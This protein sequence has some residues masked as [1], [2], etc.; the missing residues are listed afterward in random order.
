VQKKNAETARV[1]YECLYLDELLL[2]TETA[3]VFY[4]CLYLDELLLDTETARVFYECLFRDKLS[5][6]QKN[7]HQHTVSY[8]KFVPSICNLCDDLG[9]PRILGI[10][11]THQLCSHA[12]HTR[13]IHILPAS[14]IGRVLY[15]A[16]LIGSIHNALE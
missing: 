6:A 10:I 8:A 11:T 3:R 9:Q 4:E 14:E 13:R 5:V 12:I 16:Q 2:D 15:F 1:F 7:A